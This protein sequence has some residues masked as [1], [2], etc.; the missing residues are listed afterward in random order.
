MARMPGQWLKRVP[1]GLEMKEL[2]DLKDLMMSDTLLV[3]PQGLCF[4]PETPGM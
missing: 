2:R 4:C 3:W 1:K